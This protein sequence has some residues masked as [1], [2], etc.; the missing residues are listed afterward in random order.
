LDI[1]FLGLFE[2]VVYGFAWASPHYF[3][4]W[5]F[6]LI[7]RLPLGFS[8]EISIVGFNTRYSVIMSKVETGEQS[9]NPT[10][11]HTPTARQLRW[12]RRRQNDQL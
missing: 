9:V 7:E 6:Y 11:E 1:T 5:I 4:F 8:S 12:L 2:R 10:D 3:L